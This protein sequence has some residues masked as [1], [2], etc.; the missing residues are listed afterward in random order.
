[1]KNKIRGRVL[2]GILAAALLCTAIP[3]TAYAVE[4]S[5]E[6]VQGQAMEEDLF[7]EDGETSENEMTPGDGEDMQGAEESVDGDAPDEDTSSGDTDEAGEQEEL[8]SNEDAEETEEEEELQTKVSEEEK[9]TA[10]EVASQYMVSTYAVANPYSYGQCT[11][12]AWNYAYNNAGVA[13]PQLHNAGDWY[14]NAK[15]LGYAVG[16]EPRRNSIVVWSGGQY[17]HV[18]YVLVFSAYK[19]KIDII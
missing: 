1:M 5:E 19:S 9:T 6:A 14:N 11:W 12:G 7:S 15:N 3:E 18:A 10:E 8:P 16:T 2:T 17:G 4:T 13:L